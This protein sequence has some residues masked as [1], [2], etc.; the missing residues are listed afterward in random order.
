M[1]FL[2]FTPSPENKLFKDV[3]YFHYDEMSPAGFC[4]AM[5]F[6]SPGCKFKSLSTIHSPTVYTFYFI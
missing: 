5:D 3:E 4:R 2:N 1:F 6:D